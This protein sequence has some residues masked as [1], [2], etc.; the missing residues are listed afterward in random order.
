MSAAGLVLITFYE[1][2]ETTAYQDSVGVWTIGVGHTNA[3]GAPEVVPGMT[4]TEEQ[5]FDILANDI[6]QYE[7]AV[8][9]YVTVTLNQFQYDALV[10]WTYNLGAGSLAS[11]TMLKVLNSGDYWNT[12]HEL[13]KWDNAG[14]EQL[15]GLTRRRGSSAGYFML[16][17]T[18]AYFE[19]DW[20]KPDPDDA[21]D[22][23][24]GQKIAEKI[25]SLGERLKT[26]GE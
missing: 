3:A 19:H 24:T 25:K 21:I 17:N 4:I 10:S 2:I 23:K 9:Q 11:S 6:G 18:A 14:G 12:I 1:G 15:R 13:L 5:A 16:G 26:V 20:N 8:N 7:Q 22:I